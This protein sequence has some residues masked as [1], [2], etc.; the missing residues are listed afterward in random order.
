[1][2]PCPT[3]IYYQRRPESTYGLKS[4]IKNYNEITGKKLKTV[5]YTDS[6]D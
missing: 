5:N 1:M 4:N 6:K 2:D 3:L